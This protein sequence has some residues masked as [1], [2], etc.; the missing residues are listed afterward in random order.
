MEKDK[1][2]WNVLI[3]IQVDFRYVVF[4]DVVVMFFYVGGEGIR[5]YKVFIKGG[6]EFIDIVRVIKFCLLVRIEVGGQGLGL[7]LGFFCDFRNCN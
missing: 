5:F 7:G 2:V 4:L 1:V 3:I 6:Q